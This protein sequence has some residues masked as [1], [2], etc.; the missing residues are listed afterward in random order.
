MIDSILPFLFAHVILVLG[1]RYTRPSS[2]ARYFLQ[3]IIFVCCF[4]S[5]RSTFSLSIPAQAGGQYI[6]GMMM[7]SSHWMLLAH[8]SSATHA[9]PGKQLHWAIE[10][11]FSARWGVSPKMIPP[12]SRK[13]RSYVPTKTRF[14]L[15][16]SWDFVWT[17]ALLY[18]VNN[19]QLYIYD[20]DFTS[21]PDGFLHRLSDVSPTEWVIRIYMT[22][23][24]KGAP[25]LALRAGHSLVSVLAIAAGD[26]P[27]RYPPLFGSI[28]EAY[29]V[30]RFYVYV[31]K[32]VML[33]GTLSN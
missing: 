32:L 25:Y 33:F 6:W 15:S 1:L 17:A 27:E 20:S 5:V 16:R 29:R 30:R 2:P 22:I 31:S 10:M 23:I 7:S 4:I 26:S 18:F 9:P 8:A 13:D 3:A 21:V 14:L 12:F 19:Y 11:L 24:G 28:K